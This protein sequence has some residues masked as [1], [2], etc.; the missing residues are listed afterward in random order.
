L[1]NLLTLSSADVDV[2][3]VDADVVDVDVVDVDVDVDVVVDVV[4]G[5]PLVLTKRGHPR[6]RG[7]THISESS[8][9]THATPVRDRR[10]DF[11]RLPCLASWRP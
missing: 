2:D 3:V 4:A 9:R 5:S 10:Y 6:I 1:L 7:S 8:R 11:Q